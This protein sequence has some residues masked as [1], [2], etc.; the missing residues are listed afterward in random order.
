MTPGRAI[1]PTSVGLHCPRA[2]DTH[3][4]ADLRP[5]FGRL[6]HDDYRSPAPGTVYAI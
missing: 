3:A 4:V 5:T 2:L 6:Q 1:K